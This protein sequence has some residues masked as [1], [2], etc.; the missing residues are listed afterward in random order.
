MLL[1]LTKNIYYTPP[2][3][4]TDRPVMGYVKGSKYSLMVEAGNSQKTVKEFNYDLAQNGFKPA[5]FV[6]VTH[7]HW[8]HCFGLNAVNAL[9]FALDET[10]AIL[11]NM[12][13]WQW[14][15]ELLTD[16]VKNN[17]IPLFCEAHIRL[18]YPNLS[19]IKPITAD[20]SFKDEMT[21]D[22]GEQICI[23]KKVVCP[24]TDDS[25]IVYIPGEKTVFFGDAICEELVG[26]QWI[27]NREKLEALIDELVELDFDYGLEG[28]FLPKKKNIIIA[29][30]KERLLKC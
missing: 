30:M 19:E 25:I 28:H 3:E 6:V 29:E 13:S 24:H 20:I 27:D 21:I 15:D 5:D 17:K 9:S 11:E 22:L 16:Y 8:D 4:A 26:D 1:N 12:S 18:E 23:F 7:H 2:Q 14:S 10:N